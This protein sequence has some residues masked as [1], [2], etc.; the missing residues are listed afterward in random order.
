MRLTVLV[1]AT[2]V[3]TNIYGGK[4]KWDKN[5]NPI[6]EKP[7]EPVKGCQKQTLDNLI[8]DSNGS[9]CKG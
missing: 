8:Q 1:L 3:V 7:T 5:G 2:M 4:V 9:K 6:L